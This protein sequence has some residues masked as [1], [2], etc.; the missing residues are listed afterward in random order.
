MVSYA[1]VH[2]VLFG[3]FSARAMSIAGM[4]LSSACLAVAM[5]ISLALRLVSAVYCDHVLTRLRGQKS[6]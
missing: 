6:G 3:L 4:L 5:A 2:V 1:Y